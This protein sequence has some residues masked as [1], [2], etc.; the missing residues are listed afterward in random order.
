MSAT[1]PR[2]ARRSLRFPCRASRVIPPLRCRRA[3]DTG[4]PA[5]GAELVPDLA[6]CARLATEDSPRPRRLSAVMSGRAGSS[7]LLIP[8]RSCLK[9]VRST[10]TNPPPSSTRP[11]TRYPVTSAGAQASR[12]PGG[13]PLRQHPRT[14]RQ[15]RHRPRVHPA[16]QAQ[17]TDA[18]A[19]RDDAAERG[20]H[21]EV[22][23]H[24]RV[25]TSIQ[26]HLD[27]LARH[28]GTG[29]NA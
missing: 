18:T 8:S 11:S 23:R 29:P 22:A 15:L 9:M 27:R 5:R 6:T 14:V 28:T 19:L 7:P 3:G 10:P 12:S 2:C 26:K 13:T 21:T 4:R 17:I 24:A 1:R 16:L 20:C 25:I